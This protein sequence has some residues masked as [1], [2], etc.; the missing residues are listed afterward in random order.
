MDKLG[1]GVYGTVF[2]ARDM[3]TGTTVAIKRPNASDNILDHGLSVS[4]LREAALL[5]SF[6][7]HKHD[8]ILNLQDFFVRDDLIHLVFDCFHCNLRSHICDLYE[9]GQCSI[10]Q[11]QLQ[12]Y[13]RQ[14]L[15]A[16]EYCHDRRVIHRDLKPDNILL[17]EAKQQLV[18]CDFGMARAERDGDKLTDGCVTSWYRPPEIFLGDTEYG[19]AVDI[20]SAGMIMAEMINLAPVMGAAK[21]ELECLLFMFESFGTPNERTWPGVTRLPN[22]VAAFAQWPIRKPSS[23]LAFDDISPRAA[24]LLDC[25][26]Q[27]CPSSRWTASEALKEHEF[28]MSESA[29]EVSESECADNRLDEAVGELIA[30]LDCATSECAR[31]LVGS[32][33]AGDCVAFHESMSAGSKRARTCEHELLCSEEMDSIERAVKCSRQST[34]SLRFSSFGRHLCG[35]LGSLGPNSQRSESFAEYLGIAAA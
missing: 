19:P 10:D 35:A 15:S 3:S 7:A 23:V 14:I 2:R 30:V 26:L 13:M 29:S 27:L 25:L 9:S 33:S 12:S 6:A 34:R 11:D 8:N 5:K 1:S 17:D 24:D 28:F 21:T 31:P 16:L 4:M 18:I 20:W 32:E 22:N